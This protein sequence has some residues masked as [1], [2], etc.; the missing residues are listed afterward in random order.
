MGSS[1]RVGKPRWLH[2]HAELL[3]LSRSGP[4]GVSSCSCVF[5]EVIA[6]YLELT[7]Y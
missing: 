1:H 3:D 6:R 5:S 4:V 7:G 2:A